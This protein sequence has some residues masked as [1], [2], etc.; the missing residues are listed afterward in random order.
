MRTTHGE[1]RGFHAPPQILA[2]AA[3]VVPQRGGDAMVQPPHHPGG[4]ID[5][6]A[7]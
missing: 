7:P 2:H 3:E 6:V 1:V 5:E 4:V